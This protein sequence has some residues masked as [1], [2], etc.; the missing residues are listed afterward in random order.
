MIG[1]GQFH[2]DLG[3]PF[4]RVLHNGPNHAVHTAHTNDLR[5]SA[6]H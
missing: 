4:E 1:T 2:T 3:G 5:A 6:C